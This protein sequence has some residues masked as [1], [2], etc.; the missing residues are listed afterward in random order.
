MLG[1]KTS[2]GG[3]LS[4]HAAKPKSGGRKRQG[5]PLPKALLKQQARLRVAWQSDY[6]CLKAAVLADS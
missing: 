2:I 5:K 6:T 1:S 3:V 4:H